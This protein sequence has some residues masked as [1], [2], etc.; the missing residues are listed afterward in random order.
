VI[1]CFGCQALGAPVTLPV[2][3][4]VIM[5]MPLGVDW[6]LQ[7]VGILES[8]NIRRFVT[9]ILFGFALTPHSIYISITG[10]I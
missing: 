9:G 5:A 2:T 8:T 3:V 4:S 6:T 1:V 7:R 10:E